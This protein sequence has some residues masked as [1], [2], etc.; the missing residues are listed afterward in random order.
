MQLAVKVLVQRA[1]LPEGSRIQGQ[2]QG[3]GWVDPTGIQRIQ[4]LV[5]K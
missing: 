4:E 1:L 5:A 2:G 3:E